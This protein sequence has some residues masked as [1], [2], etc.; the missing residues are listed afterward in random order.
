[1]RLLVVDGS[2]I[3]ARTVKRLAPPGIEVHTLSSFREA[4]DS[5]LEDAPQALVV[6]ITHAD[7]P[8][9]DL[10]LRCRDHSPPIPVLFESSFYEDP[11]AAGLDD[12]GPR[13]VFLAKPY[14]LSDLRREIRH[15]TRQARLNLRRTAK[16]EDARP[17][18][19]PKEP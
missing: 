19:T 7:L 9:R 3:L 4:M 11:A 17:D 8:W 10:Q 5:L 13:S 1:M 16:S 12:L 15:L 14:R 6:N 18:A 2:E